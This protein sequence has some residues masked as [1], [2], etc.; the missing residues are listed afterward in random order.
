MTR[1]FVDTAFV[2]ALV[3][4]NDQ[5][6]A[7]AQNLS[8]MYETEPLII[9]D[10]VLLEIGNALA[11]DYKKEAIEIIESFRTSKEVLIVELSLDFFDKAFE[12]YKK[13][14]DKDWGMVDCISFIVMREYEVRNALTFDDHFRQAGFNV[15][16]KN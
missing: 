11:R 7:K 16:M 13:Y 2:V 4:S 1:T 6:H 9:T 3:N 5:Y 14:T 15:L 8:E 10:V 12:L